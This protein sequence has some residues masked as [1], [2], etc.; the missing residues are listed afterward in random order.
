MKNGLKVSKFVILLGLPFLLSFL[1][2]VKVL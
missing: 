1:S 2:D